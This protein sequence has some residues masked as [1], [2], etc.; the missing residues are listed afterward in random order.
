MIRLAAGRPV[1]AV[2]DVV[3]VARGGVLV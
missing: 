3:L 2:A 1:G